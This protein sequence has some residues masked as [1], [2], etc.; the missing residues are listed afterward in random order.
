MPDV[1][2]RGL[3]LPALHGTKYR[4]RKRSRVESRPDG[5]HHRAPRSHRQPEHAKVQGVGAHQ[6]RGARLRHRPPATA[7]ADGSDRR[8]SVPRSIPTVARWI[9]PI[10]AERRRGFFETG[11]RRPAH[12]CRRTKSSCCTKP[13]NFRC[14]GRP[15]STFPTQLSVSSLVMKTRDRKH[16]RAWVD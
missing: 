8:S 12:G 6:S 4:L 16:R 14:F 3:L 1:T 10:A 9:R 13:R 15:N 5:C 2:V 7:D 11:R